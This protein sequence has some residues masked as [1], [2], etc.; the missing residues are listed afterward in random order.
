MSG[1]EGSVK[2]SWRGGKVGRSSESPSIEWLPFMVSI[3]RVLQD[4]NHEM[5]QLRVSDLFRD[6]QQGVSSA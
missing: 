4:Q 2:E 1:E 5:F 6:G 3:G